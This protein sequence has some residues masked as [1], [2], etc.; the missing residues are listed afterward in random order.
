MTG[1]ADD[2]D[3]LFI[4][5]I[6]GWAPSNNTINAMIHVQEAASYEEAKALQARFEQVPHSDA[7]IVEVHDDAETDLTTVTREIVESIAAQPS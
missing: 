1:T 6:I 5:L 7:E 3:D 4:D 2:A